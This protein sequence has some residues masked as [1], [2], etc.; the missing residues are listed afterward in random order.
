MA[1]TRKPTPPAK[2]DVLANGVTF[3][4]D[5]KTYAIPPT[6]E[7]PLDALEAMEKEQGVTFAR[8]L[9]GEPQW[10]I[11]RREHSTAKDLNGLM[12]ALQEAAGLG[13]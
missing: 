9:L 11:F 6:D 5:G 13:N 3:E 7:W 2:A 12:E 10:A 8:L 4:F 1:T